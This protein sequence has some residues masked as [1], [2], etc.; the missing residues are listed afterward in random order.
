MKYLSLFFLIC[1]STAAYAQTVT[2]DFE[3]DI[4]RY[5]PTSDYIIESYIT[6]DGTRSV[7]LTPSK[8]Y[9]VDNQSGEYL[10]TRDLLRKSKESVETVQ[11]AS[12]IEEG[13]AFLVMPEAQSVAVLDWTL[14]DH[15]IEVYNLEDGTTRWETDEYRFANTGEQVAE[16]VAADA[17]VGLL[18]SNTSLESSQDEIRLVQEYLVSDIPGPAMSSKALGLITPVGNEGVLIHTKEGQAMI[19]LESGE[20]QWNFTEFPLVVGSYYH[21]PDRNEIVLVNDNMYLTG[22]SANQRMLV[23]LNTD[24]GEKRFEYEMLD[25]S[26]ASHIYEEEGLLILDLVN[27]T[28]IDLETGEEVVQTRIKGKNSGASNIFGSQATAGTNSQNVVPILNSLVSYPE[29]YTGYMKLDNGVTMA[30]SGSFGSKTTIARYDL[31][32]GEQVWEHKGVADAISEISYVDDSHVYITRTGMGKQEWY[33]LDKETGDTD[34]TMTADKGATVWH[35]DKVFLAGKKELQVFDVSTL[36]KPVASM[37]YKS[38]D[39]GK[40]EELMLHHGRIVGVAKE[41]VIFLDEQGEMLGK[42]TTEKVDDFVMTDKYVAL[43]TNKAVVLVDVKNMK[44]SGGV[45]VDLN[46]K[47][48]VLMIAQQDGTIVTI[49]KHQDLTG[50]HVK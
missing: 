46:K 17:A 2:A 9:V 15:D 39:I 32:S 14:V 38:L 35:N 11:T 5:K 30:A 49:E 37:S 16:K 4:D 47:E 12:I 13:S 43:V 45:P 36:D 26:A 21:M 18:T 25:P 41:G 23:V 24:T 10:V 1:I 6:P 27:F 40:V 29:V 50:Y 42:F 44:M 20:D 33:L 28:A 34:G 22:K 48:D 8:F 19:A 3:L 7:V 31:G